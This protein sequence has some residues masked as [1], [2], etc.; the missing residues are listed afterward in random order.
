[1]KTYSEKLKDPKW[2]EFRQRAFDRYGR[3][4]TECGEDS[5]YGE[6]HHVHHK[7]YIRDREPWQYDLDDVTVLCK[8]CHNEIHDAEQ[9]FR[10]LIRQSRPN[11]AFH[12][13]YLAQC[14]SEIDE[15]D[16][17]SVLSRAKVHAKNLKY[18]WRDR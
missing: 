9:D 16:V 3:R 13:Q 10:D 6:H 1:M 17:V 5:H 14:L 15:Y 18:G 8:M 12:F 2:E 11:V 4:C 7:R